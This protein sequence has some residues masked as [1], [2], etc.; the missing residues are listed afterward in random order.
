MFNVDKNSCY[1]RKREREKEYCFDIVCLIKAKGRERERERVMMRCD[2]VYINFL[3][4]VI[5]A[6]LYKQI[7]KKCKHKVKFIMGRG[8]YHS[9]YC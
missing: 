9:S 1:L 6:Y 7:F 3:N 4:N 5:I 2:K 8:I